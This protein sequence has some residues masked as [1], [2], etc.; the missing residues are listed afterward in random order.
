MHRDQRTRRLVSP[1]QLL[2]HSTDDGGGSAYSGSENTKH[3]K[4]ARK[5]TVAAGECSKTL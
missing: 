1:N 3:P 4:V 2:K 5:A